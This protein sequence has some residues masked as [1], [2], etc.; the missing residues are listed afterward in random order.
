MELSRLSPITLITGATTGI[1]AA[2]ARALARRSEGGLILIDAEERALDALADEIEA[3]ERVSMLAFDVTDPDRWAQASSFIHSQYGSIDWAIV[4]TD[5][6]RLSTDLV[7]WSRGADLHG[8]A[9]TLRTAMPLMSKNLQG[10]AAILT[11]TAP[12]K[13]AAGSRGGL[14]NF[15]R[16]AAEDGAPD[17]RVNAVA[18]GA[19]A[20]LIAKAPLFG[21]I[22]RET[23]SERAALE[24][25]SA[26]SPRLA[27]YDADVELMRLASLLL[28]DESSI[29]GATLVVDG[30]YRL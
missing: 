17:V 18:P 8:A 30:G 26:L 2:F 28:S 11:T 23:G 24:I 20:A 12:L 3:P 7:D 22:V 29:S 9:L 19:D 14:L 5:A 6:P 1:G 4:N 13:A 10:G 21:D 16:T 25:I 15:L 27:R